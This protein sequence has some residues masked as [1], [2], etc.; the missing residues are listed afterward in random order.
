[1]QS[2]VEHVTCGVPQGSVGNCLQHSKIIIYADDIVLF[3]SANDFT[4][5]ESHLNED[6]SELHLWLTRN[7]LLINLKKG[8]TESMLF[9]TS[10]RLNNL[11]HQSLDLVV[12]NGKVNCTKSYKYLGVSVDSNLTFN[13]HFD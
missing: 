10:R 9:G 5:I 2:N 11:E 12:N 4:I 8:K 13:E 1:M 6:L 3:T 7:E